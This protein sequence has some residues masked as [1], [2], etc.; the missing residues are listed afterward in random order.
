MMDNISERKEPKEPKRIVIVVRPKSEFYVKAR[1]STK[2][3]INHALRLI[4][5]TAWSVLKATTATLW[6]ACFSQFR[7]GTKS[8]SS[9]SVFTTKHTTVRR[10]I[11]STGALTHPENIKLS[12]NS[13]SAALAPISAV[14]TPETTMS[15]KVHS[16]DVNNHMR[17][18]RLPRL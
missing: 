3:V 16:N 2:D 5:K 13:S 8:S 12:A 15:A 9:C 7:D 10:L 11:Q 6:A 18:I 4:A 14:G 17:N 1:D